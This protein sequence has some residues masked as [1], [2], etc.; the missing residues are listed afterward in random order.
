[1]DASAA[2][3][4]DPD[5]AAADPGGQPPRAPLERQLARLERLAEAGMEVIEALVAQ[6]KG[7]GPKVVE[8]DVALAFGRVSRAVRMAELLQKE[9]AG[10]G[11]PAQAPARQAEAEALSRSAHKDRAVRIV[12]RVARDYCRRD[13]YAVSVIAKEAAERL[14]DDDI[15]GQVASR[16]VGELIALICRDFGLQPDWD[17]L[18][19]EAWAQAE[20]ASGAE[21]SPF[22]DD[23][24]A[25]DRDEADEDEG[26]DPAEPDPGPAPPLLR[27]ETFHEKLHALARDPAVLAA[28]RRDTG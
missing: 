18:A 1:M 22:L 24:D 25:D 19:G 12:R 23:W 7:C 28:A 8:G 17:A 10:G 9:L 11:E 6:A 26:E 20:I 21:G 5:S 15:Y 3:A 14:D 2:F 16:P 13:G 27:V 4:I